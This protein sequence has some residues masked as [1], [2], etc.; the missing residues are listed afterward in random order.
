MAVSTSPRSGT[1][2]LATIA[3]SAIL[4]ISRFMST[5]PQREN[6]KYNKYKSLAFN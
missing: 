2:M 3:G 6:N 5:I 1:V 4:N